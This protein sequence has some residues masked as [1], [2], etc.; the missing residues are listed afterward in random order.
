[1]SVRGAGGLRAVGAFGHDGQVADAG[2]A[3]QVQ[4]A[5]FAAQLLTGEPARDPVEVAGRLLAVQGQD[6]RGFRLAV[7]SRTRHLIA[8]DV[9]RALTDRSLVVTW[10]NRGTLHLIRSEDYWWLHKLTVRPQFEAGCRRVLARSGVTDAAVETG[11]A[12]VGAALRQDGPQTRE[13]LRTRIAAAGLPAEGNAGLHIL[14]IASARG[15][16]VRGPMIGAQHGYV[17]VRDWLGAP[18]PEPE[19]RT[20]L[21]WLARRYLAGHGPASDRDLAKWSGLPLGQVRAGLSAIGAELRERPDGLAELAARPD[22]TGRAGQRHEGGDHPETGALP[23]PRLLGAYDP[24]L[25]GWADRTPILGDHQEIVTVNGLFRPFA[26]VGG[27]AAGTW[28]MSGGQL[29]Y[30]WFA[31]L[32]PSA[33]A[34]LAAEE[35]DVRRFLAGEPALAND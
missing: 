9:D 23:P 15:L 18:P 32:P 34:A 25:L 5:R 29:T 28:G 22:S 16:A 13:Q 6:A 19:P 12:V 7:R 1:L 4:A 10:L 27:R 8:A 2:A 33:R 30:D 17:H 20:A 14:A 21:A 11:V 26:L 3:R 35:Q 31:G 24:V